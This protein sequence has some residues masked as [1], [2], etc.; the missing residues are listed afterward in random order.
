MRVKSTVLSKSTETVCAGPKLVLAR[1]SAAVATRLTSDMAVCSSATDKG[2][3]RTMSA[4]ALALKLRRNVEEKSG[5][6]RVAGWRGADLS[7]QVE[8]IG[9]TWPSPAH[10]FQPAIHRTAT[11]GERSARQAGARRCQPCA[12]WSIT[13]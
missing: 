3:R 8:P 11:P 7:R 1:V 5:L 10:L 6:E 13:S 4:A 9:S 2:K 12:R